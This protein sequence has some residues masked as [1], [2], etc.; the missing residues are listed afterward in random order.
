MTDRLTG[1]RVQGCTGL[2]EH[3]GLN[4]PSTG[5]AAHELS[6][7]VLDPNAHIQE[8]KAFRRNRPRYEAGGDHLVARRTMRPASW[9]DVVS[10]RGPPW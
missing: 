4:G 8:V 6:A 10:P 2:P 9:A 3:W 1:R 5:D 7:I